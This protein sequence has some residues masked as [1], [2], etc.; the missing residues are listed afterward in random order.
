MWNFVRWN[1]KKIKAQ[2][3]I[4][5]IIYSLIIFTFNMFFSPIRIIREDKKMWIEQEKDRLIT[6]YPNK[7]TVEEIDKPGKHITRIIMNID[8]KVTIY[9]K[10]KHSWGATFFFIDEVGLELKSISETYFNLKTNL[11]T[12]GG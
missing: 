9:L 3:R 12:Y 8:N 11:K 2:N 1:K 4:P 5:M 7:K 6:V 10:V